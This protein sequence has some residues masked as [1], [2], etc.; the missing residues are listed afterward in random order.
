MRC[1]CSSLNR[2]RHTPLNLRGKQHLREKTVGVPPF[3][4]TGDLPGFGQGTF[5]VIPN[6]SKPG[7][8]PEGTTRRTDNPGICNSHDSTTLQNFIGSEVE[9]RT[10]CSPPKRRP[11][12][13]A[14][15]VPT[16]FTAIPSAEATLGETT[17]LCW[18]CSIDFGGAIDRARP[19]GKVTFHTAITLVGRS[20]L[21]AWKTLVTTRPYAVDYGFWSGGDLTLTQ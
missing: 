16:A 1:S 4:S 6:Q 5:A 17:N 8:D 12:S 3:G 20:Q 13:Y 9:R 15:T 11:P 19:V 14:V 2:L 18:S 10:P 7:K 21:A